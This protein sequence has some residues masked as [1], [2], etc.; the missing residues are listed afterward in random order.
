MDVTTDGSGS[1]GSGGNDTGK[2]RVAGNGLW[3]VV[4]VVV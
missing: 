1:L 2:S 4:V 3:V